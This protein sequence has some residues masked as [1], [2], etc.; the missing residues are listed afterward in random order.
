MSAA[1]DQTAGDREELAKTAIR[2]EQYIGT[3]VG[4]MDQTVCLL[5]KQP[6]AIR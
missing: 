4:G 1:D 5:A 6:A 3:M 2:A